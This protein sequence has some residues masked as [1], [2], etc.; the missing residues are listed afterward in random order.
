METQ[1]I[2]LWLLRDNMRKIRKKYSVRSCTQFF[3][4]KIWTNGGVAAVTCVSRWD[5]GLSSR[6]R[7][8]LHSSGLLT[9]VWCAWPS[10]TWLPGCP[11]TSA[12]NYQLTPRINPEKR[13]S[14]NVD[15]T[16]CEIFLER[17]YNQQIRTFSCA[18][19]SKLLE[20]EHNDACLKTA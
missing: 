14:Q 7:W 15:S 3:W 1:L 16:K 13:R 2:F 20:S 5:F 19:W 8:H 12:N 4:F 11:K 10:K 9:S 17:L 18:P 6:C